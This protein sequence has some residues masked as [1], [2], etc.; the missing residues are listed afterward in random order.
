MS[1]T[2]LFLHSFRAPKA[3]AVLSFE[4]GECEG[5]SA[6]KRLREYELLDQYNSLD[7][8]NDRED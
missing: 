2:L 1:R 7:A 5:E 4:T 6:A 8:M 3:A